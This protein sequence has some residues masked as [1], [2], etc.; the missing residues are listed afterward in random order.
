M[1]RFNLNGQQHD[2]LQKQKILPPEVRAQMRAC[3]TDRLP[4]V[5]NVILV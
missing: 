2:K 5:A 4:K 1:T 3:M